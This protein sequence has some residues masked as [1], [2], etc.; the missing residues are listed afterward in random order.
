M[1]AIS[2]AQR[3]FYL[4]TG[5]TPSATLDDAITE[6]F[7]AGADH[8]AAHLLKHLDAYMVDARGTER[9]VASDWKAR[10]EADPTERITRVLADG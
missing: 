2:D 8:E 3:T 1:S 5:L 10:I 6:A 9:T 4:A 7:V